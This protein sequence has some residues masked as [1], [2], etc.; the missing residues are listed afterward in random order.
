MNNIKLQK[1]K[2]RKMQNI[3]PITLMILERAAKFK[4]HPI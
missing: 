1:F 4:V 2:Y 3:N